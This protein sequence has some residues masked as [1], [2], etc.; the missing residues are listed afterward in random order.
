MSTVRALACSLLTLALGANPTAVPTHP[1]RKQ[2]VWVSRPFPEPAEVR[3]ACPN[4]LPGT[5]VFEAHLMTDGTVGEFKMTRSSGCEGADRLLA[6]AVRRWKFRPMYE[7]GKPIAVWL[8]MTVTD[9]GG[10]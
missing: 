9:L 5:P 7:D 4:A 1:P 3:K 2:P 6:Q 8:T 10:R